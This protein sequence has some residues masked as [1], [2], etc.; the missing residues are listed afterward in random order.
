MNT[1]MVSV[2]KSGIVPFIG[3]LSEEETKLVGTPGFFTLGAVTDFGQGEMGSGV[4]SFSVKKDTVGINSLKAYHNEKNILFALLSEYIRVC[5]S[6][7]I[8]EGELNIED[9]DIAEIAGEYL[10]SKNFHYTRNGVVSGIDLDSVRTEMITD[11]NDP[12]LKALDPDCFRD[13]AMVPGTFVLA[14]YQGKS[15]IPLAMAVVTEDR[16]RSTIEWLSV[17]KEYRNKGLGKKL[18]GKV[19]ELAT[20]KGCSDIA[21]HL[22]DDKSQGFFE[23]LGFSNK[24]EECRQYGMSVSKIPESIASERVDAFEIAL[25]S[26]LNKSETERFRKYLEKEKGL[27][28][29]L[30][31]DEAI[32]LSDRKLS[33]VW[34]NDS[35][36]QAVLLVRT[37][38]NRIYPFFFNSEDSKCGKAI[39][40]EALIKARDL[41]PA[42]SKIRIFCS[43]VS[44]EQVVEGLGLPLSQND[45]W[46][47]VQRL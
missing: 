29:P 4:L 38:E 15:H 21:V 36:I 2:S 37:C 32:D 46:C 19:K 13:K 8:K 43:R 1:R 17:G 41:M 24:E 11:I 33:H 28:S 12:A 14:S 44:T 47:M 26:E 25:L 23:K 7:S 34:I 5:E 45:S 20:D 40:T 22:T 10:E 3:Y 35:G 31:V 16:D 9:Q 42:G 6:A 30:H 18:V 27:L 39:I